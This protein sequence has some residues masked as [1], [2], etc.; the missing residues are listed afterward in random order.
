MSRP[1]VADLTEQ[2]AELTAIVDDLATRPVVLP[3]LTLP[4]L[5]LTADPVVVAPWAGVRKA[6]AAGA[7]A[8]AAALGTAMLDGDLTGA[9]GYIALG[10]GLLALAATYRVP[11]ADAA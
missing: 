8:T 9:E 6:L 2:V 1:T 7:G 3:D 4:T 5:E 10:A 11:N